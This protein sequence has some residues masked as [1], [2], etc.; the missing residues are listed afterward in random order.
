MDRCDALIIG[1]GPAGST[2]ANALV[3]HGL[4]VLVLDRKAFPRDKVCAG[5][6]TPAVVEVPE[7]GPVVTSTVDFVRLVEEVEAYKFL[8]GERLMGPALAVSG[9]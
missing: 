5:W 3:R 4:D 7:L 6:I 8:P 2:C 1:G 9:N